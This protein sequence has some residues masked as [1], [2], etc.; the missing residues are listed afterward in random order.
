M[1]GAC[2]GSIFKIA[3]KNLFEDA[4]EYASCGARKDARKIAFNNYAL[5]MTKIM[6]MLLRKVITWFLG[7]FVGVKN[8][9][10]ED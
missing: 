4:Q 9:F 5:L 10:L 8:G 2:P 7:Q 1:L 3:F 6:R